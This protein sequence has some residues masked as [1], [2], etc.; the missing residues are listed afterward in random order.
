M[1]SFC[2]CLGL[3]RKIQTISF[4]F[5]A[6]SHTNCELLIQPKDDECIQIPLHCGTSLRE[7]MSLFCS[8]YCLGLPCKVK[9]SLLLFVAWQYIHCWITFSTERWPSLQREF[10][11]LSSMY[12]PWMTMKNILKYVWIVPLSQTFFA[13]KESKVTLTPSLRLIIGVHA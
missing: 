11:N 6:K 10:F 7:G 3:P 12:Y 13:T 4:F 2:H 9:S 1:S 5:F 8:L